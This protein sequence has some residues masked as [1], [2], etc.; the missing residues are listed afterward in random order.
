MSYR[1]STE[2]LLALAAMG[3]V[4]LLGMVAEAAAQR[5]CPAGYALTN[6]GCVRVAPK[7][8][9][10]VVCGPNTIYRNGQCVPRVAQKYQ[11]PQQQVAQ[12]QRC[13]GAYEV[14]RGRSCV[15]AQNYTR[16]NGV[17]VASK[18]INDPKGPGN[19]P[20]K[21][22][23][24]TGLYEVPL[25]SGGCGCQQG[26]D[27]RNGRCELKVAACQGPYE[28]PLGS[29]K[30]ACGC[31]QGYDRKDG[32]CA[33]KIAEC[34]GP[35]EMPVAHSGGTGCGCRPG[36][37]RKNGRCEPK[38]AECKGLYEVPLSSG[39]GCGCQPGYDRSDGRCVPSKI[40]QPQYC[41]G[42]YEVRYGK[43]CGCEP[44]YF[45]RDG[46]C[47]RRGQVV[48]IPPPIIVPP[49]IP[50][51]TGARTSAEWPSSWPRICNSISAFTSILPPPPRAGTQDFVPGQVLV[52]FEV[53]QRSGQG[54]QRD[55]GGSEVRR[56]H[57]AAAPDPPPCK[58]TA[59]AQRRSGFASTS[60][61]AAR[62]S[63]VRRSSKHCATTP[64]TS[65]AIRMRHSPIPTGCWTWMA[66]APFI[67]RTWPR[68][69]SIQST[70][71]ASTASLP[72]DLSDPTLRSGLLWH[73]L[74]PPVGMNAFAAWSTV[75]GS[76]DVVVA[77]IDT[78]ILPDHPAMKGSPNVLPGYNFIT[79]PEAK[80]SKKDG[81]E[82]SA[83]DNGDGCS[84]ILGS[85]WHGTHVAGTIGA[86]R[87]NNGL[88]VS[89]VNW[90]VSVLPIR[91]MGRCGGRGNVADLATAINWAAGLA[92]PGV[93]QNERKA[94]VINLSISLRKTCEP[95]EVGVLKQALEDA[96]KAGVVV[97]AAAGN[98]K[99]DAQ[100][101]DIK[102]VSPAGCPGV[103]SVAASD[104]RGRLA[105]YS[106]YGKVSVMAPGGDLDQ[107]DDN[108]SR[109]DG[110]WSFVAPSTEY[111]SG[112]AA[113]EGTS[114]AAPHVSAAIALALSAKPELRGKPAEIEKLL[115]RTVAPK[116]ADAC[117]EAMRSG[118]AGCQGDGG[119]GADRHVVHR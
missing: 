50:A 79:D 56:H 60:G 102:E 118:P 82:P 111:P 87:N 68:E 29:K 7:V 70:R 41:K 18:Q 65:R 42:P 48:V 99:T 19:V 44:G 72:S 61:G 93:P 116:P 91:A 30:G 113:K 96:R 89:G 14:Q 55:R 16:S 85:S 94:D 75:K 45:R 37:D 9:P 78:G 86:G 17:C 77:V 90:A 40:A 114:M 53:G 8:A 32:R 22:V 34:K 80:G 15:C 64:D 119:A 2:R 27:R 62:G 47:V 51:W 36:Y 69:A 46:A 117:S 92:V 57:R 108:D 97:V 63:P 25:S 6:N 39:R 12:P 81:P 35:Y 112:V 66:R 74:P 28:V 101:V 33:P 103:I 10:R 31:Q 109:P 43:V 67:S 115:K 105:H 20:Q 23:K 76:R 106:N 24:C 107:D 110:V 83:V 73:Y 49:I 71:N 58:S 4:F 88:G 52:G 95:D 104:R 84:E 1:R 3:V 11:R 38:V 59:L 21:L 54:R 5:R 13:S 100:P 98:K 26:Y